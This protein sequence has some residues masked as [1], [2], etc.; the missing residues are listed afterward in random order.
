MCK[1]GYHHL[2]L[3]LS[4]VV[5]KNT[6]EHF[7]QETWNGFFFLT[8]NKQ[9]N[10][11]RMQTTDPPPLPVFFYYKSRK[12]ELKIRLVYIRSIWSD[13]GQDKKNIHWILFL[14]RGKKF[15]RAFFFPPAFYSEESRPTNLVLFRR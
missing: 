3:L 11:K 4:T 14:Q 15:V 9:I 8:C 10:F 6:L 13:L 12:R 5:R 1:G 7:S 2:S